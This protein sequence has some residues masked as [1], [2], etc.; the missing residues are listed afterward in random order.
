MIIKAKELAQRLNVSPATIS[1]VLNNKPGISDHLRNSLLQRIKDLG[2][3]EML[4]NCAPAHSPPPSSRLGIA[5]LIYTDSEENSEKFAFYPAVLEGAEME[6]RENSYNFLVYHIT[7]G[8]GDLKNLLENANVVGAVAQVKCITEEILVDLSVLDIPYVFI[9]AYRPDL[10]VSCVCVNNEQG[11]YS[12]VRYLKEMGHR[13]IGYISTGNASDMAIE[14]RRHFHL[15][16]REYGLG[17]NRKNYYIAAEHN[18]EL[19]PALCRAFQDSP[20]KVTAFLAENDVL[21]WQAILALKRC[22][23]RIPED[24]SIIGFDDR[25]VCLLTEPNLT[26]VRNY[27]HLMGQQSI[28]MIQNKLYLKKLNMT[29]ASI[30]YEL[31]TELIIRDSVRKIDS[32]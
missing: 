6:A 16:L 4:S 30:K 12:A 27:R 17:D 29:E 26:T 15:S 19:L 25:S 2:C 28:T 13:E 5:Y 3:E 14:R 1:L 11:I 23:Y 8:E 10:A 24:I 9:D 21:A 31:P 20:P 22:G 7:P 18:T 32:I